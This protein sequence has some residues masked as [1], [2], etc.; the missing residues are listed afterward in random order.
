MLKED[1][2]ERQKDT[3]EEIQKDTARKTDRQKRRKKSHKLGISKTKVRIIL[4][5]FSSLLPHIQALLNGITDN[6]IYQQ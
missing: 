2:T 1:T 6:Q 3:K 4:S 5:T